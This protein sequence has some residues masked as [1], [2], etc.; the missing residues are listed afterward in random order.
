V[1]KL[2]LFALLSFCQLAIAA[3]NVPPPQDV[4]LQE[5]IQAESEISI[6][7]QEDGSDLVAVEILDANE[8]EEE[9][10]VRFIP[11]EEISQDLGVSFPVDI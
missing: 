7:S 5:A 2:F 10:S 3:E 6:E 11:T 8:E 4:D 1:R 9:S